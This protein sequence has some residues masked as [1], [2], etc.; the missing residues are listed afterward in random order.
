MCQDSV[1]AGNTAVNEIYM[2]SINTS[3]TA[4]QR[5]HLLQNFYSECFERKVWV[6]MNLKRERTNMAWERFN[7]LGIW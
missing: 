2:C 4:C 5:K 1:G 7:A 6:L 3:P